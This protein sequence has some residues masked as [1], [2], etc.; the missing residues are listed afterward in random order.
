MTMTRHNPPT[1]SPHWM[2]NGI[3]PVNPAT[4]RSVWDL[5]E[6][7]DIEGDELLEGAIRGLHD[8]IAYYDEGRSAKALL[9]LQWAAGCALQIHWQTFTGGRLPEATRETTDVLRRLPG[10]LAQMI[11]RVEA[12]EGALQRQRRRR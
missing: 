3:E 1:P 10:L 6:D 8:A 9:S 2:T 12:A 11:T 5:P 4:G 7:V